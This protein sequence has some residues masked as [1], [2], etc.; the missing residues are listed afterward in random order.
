MAERGQS[1]ALGYALIF[2]VI[3]LSVALVTISGQA[4]L[5]ELRDSQRAA[6]VEEGF[7]VVADNVD[8]IFQGGAPSR[9]T[10]L[11]LSGGEIRLGQPVT[12][13]VTASDGSDEVFNHS[14]SVRPIVY[15]GA[16][17]T[18]LVY[19]TGAI[20]IRGKDGGVAM[21]REPQWLLNS[22][23]TIVPVANTSLDRQQLRGASESVGSQS[24][25]LVKTERRS[26][27]TLAS[28]DE[29]VDLTITVES[30]RSAAWESYFEAEL[31]STVDSHDCTL[32]GGAVSCEYTTDRAAVVE[33]RIAVSFR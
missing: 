5:E 21:L 7:S 20:T 33:S 13:T 1:E 32:S 15:E 8:D 16:D 29:S 14:R 28:T 24:R 18:R 11:D 19:A 23:Y 12:V 31:G 6:N 4:G 9:S 22:N 3:V 30:P 26:Q 27:E 10:E 17:G 25:V 2:A